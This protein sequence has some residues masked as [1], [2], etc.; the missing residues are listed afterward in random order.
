MHELNR[1]K[2]KLL[3]DAIDESGGFYQ[4]HSQRDCRSLM[5]VTFRLANEELEKKFLSGAAQLKLCERIEGAPLGWRHSRVD[6]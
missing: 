6:L 5:N 4:G 1:A 2:A 3:Y